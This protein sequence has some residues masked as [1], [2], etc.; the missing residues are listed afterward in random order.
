MD[1]DAVNQESRPTLLAASLVFGSATVLLSA[2][3]ATTAGA[4]GPWISGVAVLGGAFVGL[5]VG[6]RWVG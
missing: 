2:L 4:L 6:W 1:E 5:T 3:L